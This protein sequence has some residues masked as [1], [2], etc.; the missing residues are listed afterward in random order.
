ML[1]KSSWKKPVG[2]SNRDSLLDPYSLHQRWP[3][4]QRRALN[5]FQDSNLAQLIPI[6][7]DVTVAIDDA[8]AGRPWPITNLNEQL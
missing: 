4:R 7:Q 8:E 3:D 6:P 5:F 2:P 1:T